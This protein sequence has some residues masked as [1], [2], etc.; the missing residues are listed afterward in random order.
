MVWKKIGGRGWKTMKGKPTSSLRDFSVLC[1]HAWLCIFAMYPVLFYFHWKVLYQL[2][3]QNG[4]PNSASR[5]VSS[6]LWQ[7]G[8][9]R[10]EVTF[11][12]TSTMGHS[13][14]CSS[15]S[16]ARWSL[17]SVFLSMHGSPKTPSSYTQN[18]PMQTKSLQRGL[19]KFVLCGKL[20]L[21]IMV[22]EILRPSSKHYYYI[23]R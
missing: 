10:S 21:N 15:N 7:R 3:R 23:P 4:Y 11:I 2:A 20:S 5:T 16:M 6:K 22:R 14:K 13:S 19:N 8:A 18:V 12:Q 1:K 17:P 9:V